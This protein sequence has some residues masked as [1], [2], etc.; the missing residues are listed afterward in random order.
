[1]ADSKDFKSLAQFVSVEE[2]TW[3]E[4]TK[5]VVR[6][7]SPNYQDPKKEWTV[8]IN[9]N[10]VDDALM[11]RITGLSI[12]DKFCLTTKKSEENPKFNDLVDVGPASDAPTKSKS[13]WKGKGGF[14]RDETGIAVGAAWTNAIEIAKLTQRMAEGL[15]EEQVIDRIAVLVELVLD[16]KLAQEAK[17]RAK[18][19]AAQPKEEE[20]TKEAK[21]L[22]KLEQAKLKKEQEAAKAKEVVQKEEPKSEP[23]QDS[24]ADNADL[25]DDIPF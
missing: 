3:G 7:T 22:S 24:Q 21:P 19:A 6:Y 14:A 16:K 25:E 15:S 12:G 9:V 5:I 23:T 8:G 2:K 18:K 13:D 17:L 4:L 20:E 1:M 10:D 11:D